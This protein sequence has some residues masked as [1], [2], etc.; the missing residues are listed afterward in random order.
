MRTAST[1]TMATLPEDLGDDGPGQR[2]PHDLTSGRFQVGTPCAEIWH[3][4]ASHYDQ[5]EMLRRWAESLSRHLGYAVVGIWL[6][7]GPSS[8]MALQVVGGGAAADFGSMM[9]LARTDVERVVAT[10]E[11]RV[12]R[13]LAADGRWRKHGPFMAQHRVVAL[14]AYPLIS[15]G[16]AAGAVVAF[17]RNNGDTVQCH[18]LDSA[19]DEMSRA[20][21]RLGTE[22]RLRQSHTVLRTIMHA[23]PLGIVGLDPIG[24]ITLWSRDAQRI[25]GWSEKEVIDRP[26]TKTA[27][28]NVA[29]FQAGLDVSLRLRRLPSSRK[30]SGEAATERHA[31]SDLTTAP[32]YAEGSTVAG[33]IAIVVDISER[34]AQRSRVVITAPGEPDLERSQRRRTTHW[35]RVMQAI[36]LNLGGTRGEYWQG[37][38]A[39]PS[40]RLTAA[41]HAPD[42]SAPTTE[43]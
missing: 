39:R 35:R 31:K 32:Q 3:A 1:V 13:D 33:L 43:A 11:P 12:L 24:N 17:I 9:Q 18:V 26:F 4:L 36:C 23:A 15:Q 20:L 2:Q 41:W 21:T 30:Q 10:Q 22:A 34:I 40:E 7:D 19:I 29:E 25:F 28:E 16:G 8:A 38:S 6:R 27:I 37:R 14:A 42:D 5:P